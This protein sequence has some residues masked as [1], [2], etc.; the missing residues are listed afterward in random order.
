MGGAGLDAQERG[1]GVH[2]VREVFVRRMLRA[3]LTPGKYFKSRHSHSD[4]EGGMKR[5]RK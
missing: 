3:A 1:N 5:N 2:T 4:E